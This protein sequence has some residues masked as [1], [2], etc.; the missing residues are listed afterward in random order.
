MGAYFFNNDIRNITANYAGGYFKKKVHL[1]VTGGYQHNNLDGNNA[2]ESSRQ[3][4]SINLTYSKNPLSVGLTY[5]NYTSDLR[6]VLNES[7]DSLN[8]LIVTQ[9]VG[10]NGVYSIKATK[11]RS[12]VISLIVNYQDV[13]D[14][15]SIESRGTESTLTTVTGSYAFKYPKLR[16]QMIW[17]ANYTNMVSEFNEIV[18]L[19]LGGKFKKKLLKDHL[20]LSLGI[21]YYNSSTNNTINSMLQAGYRFKKRHTLSLGASLISRFYRSNIESTK[22]SYSETIGSVAYGYT[23]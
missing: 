14:G 17:S 8:A 6:Y 13:S 9:S 7:L 12:E 16:F 20:N 10:I 2:T 15:F 22:T 1:M 5:S 18:R 4:G 19:G 11:N 23:F 21:N 3:I